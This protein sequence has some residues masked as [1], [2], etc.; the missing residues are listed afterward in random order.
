M[1]WLVA[2][3]YLADVCYSWAL[4]QCSNCRSLT[5]FLLYSRWQ[6]TFAIGLAVAI[7]VNFWY[8]L[9]LTR[10]IVSIA[11]KAIDV[12]KYFRYKGLLDVGSKSSFRRKMLHL[13]T[14]Q[15]MFFAFTFLLL[16]QLTGSFKAI[17]RNHLTRR[18]GHSRTDLLPSSKWHSRKSSI[19]ILAYTNIAELNEEIKKD[20][21]RAYELFNQQKGVINFET[22]YLTLAALT[23]QGLN[24]PY[25]WLDSHGHQIWKRYDSP[26]FLHGNKNHISSVS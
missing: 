24:Y 15:I 22:A 5:R 1:L 23:Q 21:S 12:V 18:N 19:A 4:I 2:T 6:L 25:P 26:M 16:P 20:S 11:Y 17:S 10:F 7:S 9:H 8:P 3:A 14:L 13:S